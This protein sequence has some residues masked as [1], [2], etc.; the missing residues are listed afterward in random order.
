MQEAG[1]GVCGGE[2]N[3]YRCVKA[4]NTFA[5]EK[6]RCGGSGEKCEEQMIRYGSGQVCRSSD[7]CIK[8]RNR[9]VGGE[10]QV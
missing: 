8:A 5:E 10:V 2:K 9:C 7:R 3:D 4:W 1:T 6:I